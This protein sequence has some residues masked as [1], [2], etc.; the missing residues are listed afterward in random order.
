VSDDKRVNGMLAT[1][2][3]LGRL[4]DG[5]KQYVSNVAFEQEFEL[6]DGEDK[7]LLFCSDGLLETMSATEAVEII[8]SFIGDAVTVKAADS[9]R[10]LE[11]A[12]EL[13]ATTAMERGAMDNITVIIVQLLWQLK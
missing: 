6:I 5:L 4:P 7:F 1:S 9:R 3:G 12:A 13:V 8:Y 10:L 2:R 11:E